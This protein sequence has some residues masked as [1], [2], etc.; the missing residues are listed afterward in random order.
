M[1][2]WP[3]AVV[4]RNTWERLRAENEQYR[5]SIG[6]AIEYLRHLTLGNMQATYEG[7]GDDP[8]LSKVLFDLQERLRQVSIEE[9]RQ[10]WAN[11]GLAK[12]VHLIREHRELASL[13]NAFIT[14]LVKY[15]HANQGGLFILQEPEKGEPYL[16]L[17]ACYAYERR[18]FLEKKVFVGEGLLGQVFLEKQTSLMT[19]VPQQYVRITS[20]LG[21]ATPTNILIVPLM[22]GETPVGVLEMASFLPFEEH[23]VRFV[24]DM[25]GELAASVYLLSSSQKL[26]EALR[27][28]QMITE[29]LR[30]QEEELRQNMEELQATQEESQSI[31]LQLRSKVDAINSALL[32]IEF[33]P[34]GYI[35]QANDN[36][37]FGVGYSRD[38][39]YGQHHRL[40]IDL[41][42]Q[43][44]PEYLKFWENLRKGEAFTQE[45]RRIGKNEREIWLYAAYY[46]VLDTDGAV[47]K[48][49]KI[50]YDITARKH[51]EKQQNK[52]AAQAD[53]AMTRIQALEKEL[54]QKNLQ[55]ELLNQQLAGR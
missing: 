1:N 15:L 48:V 38:E 29:Q 17:M 41:T 10:Q 37:V 52:Q 27:Q 34:R 13:S 30:S 46:P 36:F 8:A 9:Q 20:G 18:K 11:E 43:D 12:F 23:Q 54:A 5:L 28:S 45:V 22:A 6:H 33:D 31:A 32:Y 55:I 7:K 2:I 53:A 3:F 39:L 40:L 14:Q 47:S 21:E 26:Q 44:T 25:A 19:E 51:L 16:E 24:E 49:I 42:E 35:L 4:W 50:A